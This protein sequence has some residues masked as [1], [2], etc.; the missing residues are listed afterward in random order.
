M[1]D[2]FIC[3]LRNIYLLRNVKINKNKK[4][5]KTYW[6]PLKVDKKEKQ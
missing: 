1:Y 3:R 5:Y 6:E 4:I 2:T